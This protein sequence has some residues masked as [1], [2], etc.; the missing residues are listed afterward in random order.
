MRYDRRV[1]ADS[2]IQFLTD[3]VLLRQLQSDFLLARYSVLLVDE[4]HERSL[5]TDMLLGARPMERARAPA[6][7]S[8][9][10]ACMH[11]SRGGCMATQAPKFVFP[12]K[13]LPIPA[14]QMH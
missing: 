13:P 10:G 1:G 2:A 6:P 12:F 11:A 7:R 5:N 4:A 3:G 14:L 8:R 9:A